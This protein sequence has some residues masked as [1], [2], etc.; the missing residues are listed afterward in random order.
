MAAD[1]VVKGCF[2]NWVKLTSLGNETAGGV[3]EWGPL[4][5]GDFVKYP[6]RVGPPLNPV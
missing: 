2:A 5:W 1:A 3:G 6:C 4:V